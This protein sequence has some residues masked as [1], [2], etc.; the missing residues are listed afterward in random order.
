VIAQVNGRLFW[1]V[2]MVL[3]AVALPVVA[4]T[5]AGNGAVDQVQ[6]P[7]ASKPLV[8]VE[9]PAQP[10]LDEQ[11]WGGAGQ[12]GDRQAL[13]AAV[14]HSLRYLRTARAAA[15]YRKSPVPGITCQRVERSLQRFRQLLLYT[16]SPTELQAFVEREFVFY[17]AT[18]KDGQG[19]VGFTGYFEPVHTAS[20]KPTSEFRYPIYRQPR[21]FAAWSQPHPTRAQLEGMDGL[22]AAQGK[23]RGLELAW[24]RDRLEAYLIQVQGSA[25]LRL[26]DGR[27]ITVGYAGHTHYPYVSLGKELVNA[28]KIKQEDLSL[29]VVIRYFQQNPADLDAY[30]PRNQRFVFFKET[31][32]KNATGSLGVPVTP[33]RSIATDKSLFPP[34]ALALIQTQIPHTNATGQLEPRPVSRYV[35]DQDTGGAIKGAGRV[36]I[37]MG[38]GKLAGDRAG[39]I[40]TPGT[41]Y[42]LLLK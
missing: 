24:L 13:L 36:D 4:Q 30:L 12:R 39:L 14:D 21:D 1:G 17:Q 20:P 7:T 16:R 28:G 15:D 35:L 11:I 9:L 42:Y 23:L 8:A 37:F 22:Q 3:M 29:P 6:R 33:E 41:L 26:T 38:T 31:G 40:N 25:R 18:G 10:G 27:T 34:G 2:G 19:T 5:R 32:G